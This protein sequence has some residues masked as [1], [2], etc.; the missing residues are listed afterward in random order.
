MTFRD[1]SQGPADYP[2]QSRHTCPKCEGHLSRV[3]RRAI[4]RLMSFFQPVQRYRC[5]SFTCQWEGNLRAIKGTA[6]LNTK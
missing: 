5:N 4:D 2:A 3:P 1:S 6:D